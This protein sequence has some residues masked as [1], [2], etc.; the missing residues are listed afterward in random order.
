[1]QPGGGIIP[2]GKPTGQLFGGI[3]VFTVP[4]I[5]A[6][7]GTIGR[8]PPGGIAEHPV[9]LSV[10][11][12]QLQLQQQL[13]KTERSDLPGFVVLPHVEK[14]AV[15]QDDTNHVGACLEVRCEFVGGILYLLG[16]IGGCR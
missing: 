8:H 2:G 3:V 9:N 12:L 4:F 6:T 10:S 1:V 15:A 13:G 11:C 5:V 7:D 16:E 14:T